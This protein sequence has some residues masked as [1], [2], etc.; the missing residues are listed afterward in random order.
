M[1]KFLILI[2]ILGAF[3]RF[4][5]I[6]WDSFK[7]FHPDERNISWAVT[8][9]RFFDQ[10]NPKFFA[11]GGLPIYL[12][13]ALGEGV[14]TITHNPAWLT[15]WGRIAVIGRC[16][17]ATLSTISILLIYLV[18]A[19]YFAPAVGVLSAAFLAFSPWAI[20]EAHFETTETMLVFFLLLLLLLATK[21]STKRTLM[22][23]FVWGLAMAAKTTSSLFGIIP[24]AAIWLPHFLKKFP[25]KLFYTFILLGVA[26][27][28]FY[29]FSPYTLLDFTHFRESMTYESGVAL[30][31]FTVPYTL[32]FLHTT[33]YLYQIQTMLWQAGPLVIVGIIGLILLVVSLLT[34]RNSSLVTFLIFPIIYFGWIGS[35]FAKFNRYNVPF[36][37]F[38]TV[39]AAWLMV[40]I[41]NKFL[42]VIVG[43]ITIYW[44]LAN[45]T[46]YL[47]PQ[48]R[49]VATEWMFAHIPADAI[50]YTEHWNDGLPLDLPDAIPYRREVLTVYEPD[51]DAKK[52]YYADNLVVGDFII[53]STRRVWATMPRL[54]EKYP[55]TKL[56][57]ERLLNGTLGYKEVGTFTSYPQLFD[58]VVND[59]GAEETIQVYDHPTVRIFQNVGRYTQ[60]QYLKLLT[61]Y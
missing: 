10:L 48:T 34:T 39:A 38:V 46:I 5:H 20:R 1:K 7:A 30:G 13:R 26:V 28:I 57:Y 44:C 43:V 32:Q 55:L 22:L 19:V 50:I 23:G 15:D 51:N 52:N 61:G 35:W 4:T 21:I 3:F 56:F 24:I 18:G 37:P 42:Y 11:Y 60:E 14:V 6:N 36:L 47:R 54:G 31:R 53:L 25:R 8:R 33:P 12:Y 17:S 59:D 29:V 49:F 27:I 41:H 9:I 2:I 40:K 16:V 45:F 58:I